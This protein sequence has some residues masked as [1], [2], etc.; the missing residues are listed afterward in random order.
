M[1]YYRIHIADIAYLTKQPRGIFTAVWKLVDD[2]TMNEEEIKEYWKNREYFEEVL[3]VPPY[4]EQG[5]PDG[6]ITWFKDNKKG[7]DIY[8]Q[9]TFYRAMAK[10]YGVQLYKSEV[11]EIPGEVIYEDEFQIA[12][13]NQRADANIITKLCDLD[14][15]DR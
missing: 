8:K 4:Y 15:E 1:K 11:D 3:P 12:V 13:K 14:T 2:K 6:A 10:K 5:N 9:M 7:N